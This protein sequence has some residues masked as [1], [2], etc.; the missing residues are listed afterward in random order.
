VKGMAVDVLEHAGSQGIWAIALQTLAVLCLVLAALLGAMY[1]LRRLS[2]QQQGGG[3]HPIV[4]L[5][6]RALGARKQILLLEV[7]GERLL[8]GVAPERIT[9]LA[10]LE[11]ASPQGVEGPEGPE[12]EQMSFGKRLAASL[13]QMIG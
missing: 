7:M 13:R 1:L 10:R 5:S 4:V 9:L 3:R 8:V 11:G 6:A 2:G 12:G